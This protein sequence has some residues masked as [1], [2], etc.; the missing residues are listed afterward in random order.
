MQS[1]EIT[2]HHAE[3]VHTRPASVFVREAAKFKS[4]IS[5]TCDGLTVNGKSIMGLLM[6]AM[7]PGAVVTISADG[8]DER[9]ALS[10]LQRVLTGEFK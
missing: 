3:G 2:I 4:E 8:A 1:T 6:L 7:G 10:V 9:E 5:L